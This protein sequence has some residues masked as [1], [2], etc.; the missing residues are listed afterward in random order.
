MPNRNRKDSGG[1]NTIVERIVIQ[2]TL[3]ALP[4]ESNGLKNKYLVHLMQ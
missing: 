4:K 3:I 2:I 1:E